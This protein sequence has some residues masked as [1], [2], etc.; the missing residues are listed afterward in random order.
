MR[1]CRALSGPCSLISIELLWTE[2]PCTLR[3]LICSLDHRDP[4][5][6]Q[7]SHWGPVMQVPLR[8]TFEIP[9]SQSEE[10]ML[11]MNHV[12]AKFRDSAT[13]AINCLRAS[14][15]R[16]ASLPSQGEWSGCCVNSF[17]H[18]H[19]LGQTVPSVVI[20]SSWVLPTGH[21]LD[22]LSGRLPARLLTQGCLFQFSSPCPPA[23]L[24]TVPA[25]RYVPGQTHA[26]GS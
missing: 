8:S 13:A 16:L 1:L 23:C 6:T 24:T 15:E 25:S 26:A 19:Q 3:A 21:T 11:S 14:L 17:L 5:N 9:D 4:T 18:K 20:F 22:M 10:Q 2:M 7:G 12:F